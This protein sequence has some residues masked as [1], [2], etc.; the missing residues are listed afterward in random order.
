M[1]ATWVSVMEAAARLKVTHQTIRNWIAVGSLRGKRLPPF[2]F[3][4]VNAADVER[5]RRG[6]A[7]A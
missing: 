4:V 5:L 1:A 6:R 2:Q 7:D 3:H